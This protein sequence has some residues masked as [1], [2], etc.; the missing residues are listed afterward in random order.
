ME[1]RKYLRQMLVYVNKV[2]H[3]GEKIKELKDKRK[4][5]IYKTP[6]IALI[7]IMGFIVQVRSFNRI[8]RWITK[9]KRF[10]NLFPKMSKMPKIDAIRGSM[11]AFNLKS[12]DKMH[13]GEIKK[14][15]KNKVFRNGTIRGFKV[16]A[17]DG[18]ELFESTKKSCE[19]CLTRVINGVT[20]Y[21]HRAVVAMSVG[22]DPHIILGEEMLKPKKDGSNKDEGEITGA[23]RLLKRLAD[24]YGHFADIIVVDALYMKVPIINDILEKAMDAVIRLK[25]DRLK[26]FRD[27]MGIFRRTEATKEWIQSKNL[28]VQVWDEDSFEFDGLKCNLRVLRFIEYY[29]KNGINTEIKEMMVATTLSKMVPAEI[30]WEIMHKRWDIEDN[31]FHILKTYYHADHCFMHDSVAIE[32][33]FMLMIIAFNLTE[34]FLFKCLR[35]F[36]KKKM[37]RIDVIEDLRDE[38]L[39]L[40]YNFLDTG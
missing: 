40:K 3:L 2:Y 33:I 10:K 20:H 12:L 6:M 39:T 4:R 15:Y 19:E 21:F 17:L 1:S 8:Q 18:V 31:G 29:L 9:G 24:K 28:I 7:V 35:D 26:I 27:A 25:D 11:K 23:K 38:M 34:M 37:L 13:E 16:V 5:Q 36:R 14:I 32:A 22:S 30:I